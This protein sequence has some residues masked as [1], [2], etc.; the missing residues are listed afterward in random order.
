M[1]TIAVTKT[2]H[3]TYS[4][5]VDAKK[6]TSH[7]VTCTPGF[8][9]KISNERVSEERFIELSFE[10]LLEKIPNTDVKPKFDL[11][12]IPRMYPDYERAMFYKI[13]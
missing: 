9:R 6:V 7:T 8:Y 4:V 3:M 5:Q 12:W 1:A 2:D 10:F 13:K 11:P